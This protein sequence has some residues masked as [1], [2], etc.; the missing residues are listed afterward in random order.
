MIGIAGKFG[1]SVYRKQI[2]KTTGKLNPLKGERNE[3]IYTK[4]SI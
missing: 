1:V 2:G 4:S 3:T